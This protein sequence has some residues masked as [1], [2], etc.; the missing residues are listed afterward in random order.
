MF[1]S[2]DERILFCVGEEGSV[3]IVEEGS[4]FS[5]EGEGSQGSELDWNGIIV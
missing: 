3:F 5:I 4:M 2:K 1:G